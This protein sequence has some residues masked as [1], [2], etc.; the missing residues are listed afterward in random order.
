MTIWK[1]ARAIWSGW[2]SEKTRTLS[3]P[4]AGVN[5]RDDSLH[6]A[7]ESLRALVDD[8]HIPPAVRTS[9]THDFRQVEAMLEKLEYG[10]IHIAVF[11]RVGVGKS[12]LINALIGERR[13]ATSPLHGET[14]HAQ[15]AAWEEYD[16]GGVFLIDTPGINEVGGEAREQLAHEVASRADLVLY[17]VDGDITEPELTALRRL[18]EMDRPVLLVLNKCDLYAK[19]DRALVLEALR[20]RTAEL[21]PPA[22]IVEAAADPAMQTVIQVDS[23]GVEREITRQPAAEL[24]NLRQRL[25]SV[26]ET[27]GKTLVALNATLFAGRLSDALSHRILE[28]KREL[29]E[30]VVRN[31]CLAKGML[32]GF[33]PVPVADLVAV[34]AVDISLVVHLSRIYGLP[35]TRHEASDLIRTIGGQMALIMG[36]VW[37]V[38]LLSSALKGGS[39][40]LSTVLTGAAQ[41]AVA[42]YSTYI[43]GQAAHRYFRQGK[44][45]GERGPKRVVE[46]ILRSVDR[47]SLLASARADI[48]GR[49]RAR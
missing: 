13:F 35:V 21:L 34:A 38:H 33:N 41:G 10:H 1:R 44:S 24:G 30:K 4:E 48:L 11:G 8:P 19:H 32:V 16:A 49:L 43:I 39:L 23:T 3:K 37:A 22:H 31:Y 26:L 12:A 18:L 5:T 15:V 14:R 40:G 27:E 36:T 20:N 7:R 2:R 42:Y 46:E 45:W 6:R 9:L 25:W 29:A 47:D 17:V 28:I